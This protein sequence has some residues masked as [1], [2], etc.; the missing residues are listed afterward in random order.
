MNEIFKGFASLGSF[1]VVRDKTLKDDEFAHKKDKLYM[2]LYAWK[3]V[4]HL[5]NGVT[6][7]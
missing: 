5:P 2:G 7:G 1:K 3:W 6:N 4:K